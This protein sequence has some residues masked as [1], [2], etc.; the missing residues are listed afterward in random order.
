MNQPINNHSRP[1]H[2]DIAV[3]VYIRVRCLTLSEHKSSAEFVAAHKFNQCIISE[4]VVHSYINAAFPINHRVCQIIQKAHFFPISR[5]KLGFLE[6]MRCGVIDEIPSRIFLVG[7]D[8]C[9]CK[10]S[11]AGIVC[12]QLYIL[13]IESRKFFKPH[14]NILYSLFSQFDSHPK[15][16]NKKIKNKIH[17]DFIDSESSD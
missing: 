12:H 9:S 14:K 2:V 13:T 8:K 5:L 16:K 4:W 6:R 3:C 10:Y 1:F 7:N 17:L 15:K 11:C